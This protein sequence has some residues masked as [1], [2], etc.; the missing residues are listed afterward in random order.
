MCYISRPYNPPGFDPVNSFGEIYKLWS[1]LI[2]TNIMFLDIIHRPVFF[3]KYLVYITKHNISETGF[4]L[5]LQVKPTQLGQISRASPYL[6]TLKNVHWSVEM[7]FVVSTQENLMFPLNLHWMELQ[8]FYFCCDVGS[9]HGKDIQAGLAHG[10]VHYR[11]VGGFLVFPVCSVCFN[12]QALCFIPTYFMTFF[13][14][15]LG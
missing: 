7:L 8:L 11:V 14:G 10:M 3:Y 15:M 5:H 4:C 13:V 1:A 6:R 2:C 12:L 9:P